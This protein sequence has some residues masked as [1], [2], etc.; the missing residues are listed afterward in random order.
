[1]SKVDVRQNNMAMFML[2]EAI[3]GER[4]RFKDLH[5]DENGMYDVTITLNG[6]EA[7]TER[8][9]ENLH[10]SYREA[11]QKQARDLLDLEYGNIL[12]SIYNIQETLKEHDKLFDEKVPDALFSPDAEENSREA[13][14]EQEEIDR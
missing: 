3:G 13:D 9:I 11:V 2:C 1:M 12:D 10:R 5:A 8:F 7:D 14:A 6:I 4:E